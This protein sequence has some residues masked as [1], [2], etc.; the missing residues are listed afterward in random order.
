MNC[1]NCRDE[2]IVWTS[3]VVFGIFTAGPCPICNKNGLAVRKDQ[4]KYDEVRKFY[5]NN[6]KK[7]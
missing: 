5:E 6:T 7:L 1:L 2:R 4:E 3:D